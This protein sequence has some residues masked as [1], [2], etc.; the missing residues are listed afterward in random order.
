MPE[1]GIPERVFAVQLWVA[2][3]FGRGLVT[4]YAVEHENR[5][6]KLKKECDAYWLSQ[7]AS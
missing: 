1:V 4:A 3:L 6:L 7:A 2:R 5:R